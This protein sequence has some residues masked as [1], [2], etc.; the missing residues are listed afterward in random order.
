MCD[1]CEV[2]LG[3]T[4]DRVPAGT[5]M[6]LIFSNEEERQESLLKF[7]LSGLESGERTAC[8]SNR[9]DEEGL[10]AFLNG[11]GISYEQKKREKAISLFGTN[12]VY[13]QGGRFDPDRM[14]NTLSAFYA[15]SMEMGFTAARV[16]GEMTPEVEKVPG[17]DRLLEYESRVSMLLREHPVTSVCQYDATLFDGATILE[18][19]KVHPKM[20][21]NGA[22]V[23]NPFF[24]A[25]EEYLKGI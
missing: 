6:C 7:L 10:A 18:I 2:S 3:F 19:L 4:D 17:G 21:V 16:I 11:H 8:F 15:E 20:I 5:H 22:V 25:P 23:N 12:E 9:T 1:H 24:I 14:L 13:F